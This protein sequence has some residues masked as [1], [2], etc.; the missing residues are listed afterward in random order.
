MALD[1][2]KITAESFQSMVENGLRNLKAHYQEINDLNVFPVPDGDTGTNM[3]ATLKGGVEAMNKKE[4]EELSEKAGALASGMLL[5]ARGNSGVILSQFFAGIAE[6]FQGLHEADLSQFANALSQGTA[7]AY[8]AVVNPVEGTILTVAKDGSHAV[9]EAIGT[10]KS[11][12]SV[13]GLLSRSMSDS[14]KNTP[15]LLPVLKEA[16]VIDSGGAGLLSVMEGMR[17]D[18]LGEEIE[19]SSFNGPSNAA[20]SVDLSAFNE[21]SV[22]TYG[23]CTEFILQLQ[24]CKNGPENFVLEDMIDTFKGYG[25]SIVALRDGNIV[26]V[27]VHTKTPALPIEYA[28]R[29][30]EFLTFK[31]ENMNLQHNEILLKGLPAEEEGEEKEYGIVAVSPSPEISAL[32]KEMKVDQIVS[33]GQ[34]MNPS[35]DDFVKAFKLTHAKKIIVFP[36]NGNIILTAKQ[37]AGLYEGSEIHVVSSKSIVEAYSA[38]QLVDFESYSLEENLENIQSA[39]SS[40]VSGAVSVAV[41]DSLNNGINVTKGDAIGILSGALVADES[42]S[43]DCLFKTIAQVEDIDDRSVITIFFGKATNEATKE[44][45][46]ARIEENYPL[47]D[48]QSFDGGQDVYPFIFAIE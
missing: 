47:M 13:F 8:K 29:Y 35:A 11:L 20:S 28:Q 1:M 18:V 36:N 31:M 12:E 10:M 37:A 7:K 43:V 38:L 21:D 32:F 26:K 3:T 15:N 33:G 48:Y 6:A 4:S 23:Y 25:D 40:V 24:N 14:L 5:S 39:I 44:A 30:G 27:H 16:G 22:L 42:D 34:S 46:G 19:D 17:K 2:D 41:R 9:A 45:V